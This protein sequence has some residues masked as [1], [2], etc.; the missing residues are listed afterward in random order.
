M[1]YLRFG[2]NSGVCQRTSEMIGARGTSEVDE[3]ARD[4]SVLKHE[5]VS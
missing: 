4:I 2:K 3:D 1:Q 5:T